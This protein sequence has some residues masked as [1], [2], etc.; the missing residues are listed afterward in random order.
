VRE[1]VDVVVPVGRGV[2]AALARFRALEGATLW[3][4]DDAGEGVEAPEVVRTGG[5]RGPG[6]ARNAGAAAGRAPWV[7]F[8]DADVE[9]PADL[10]PRLLGPPVADDVGAV[11]GEV[12]DGPGGRLAQRWARAR[13]SMSQ[14]L[15]L[16][17]PR[18]F[19]L[20]ACL[21]VRR[22]AFEA[23]GGFAE[24]PGTGEDADLC[25]RLAE[26]GWRLEPRLDVAV[27]HESRATVRGLLAQRA[28]HGEAAAW[29]EERWPGAIPPR[30]LPGLA[31]WGVRQALRA[32]LAPDRDEAAARLLDGPTALAFELGRRRAQRR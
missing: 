2:R 28:W 18:P 16:S 10:V 11:A 24:P 26:A 4:V 22:A 29:V 9:A 21:A 3:V 32:P 15:V 8:V 7:L 1:D 5:G 20:T 12:V 25:F 30:R 17:G 27:V 19:A 6:A 31:W 14:R 23:V 13:G